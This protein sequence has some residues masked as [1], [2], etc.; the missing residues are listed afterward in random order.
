MFMSH[1]YLHACLRLLTLLVFTNLLAFSYLLQ[2]KRLNAL[3]TG[4][5]PWVRRLLAAALVENYF[6]SPY[7]FFIP[8]TVFW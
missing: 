4:S 8:V 7:P 2:H 3:F 6:V 1:A 5:A